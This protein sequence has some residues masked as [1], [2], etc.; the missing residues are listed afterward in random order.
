[1]SD[2]KKIKVLKVISGTYIDKT[3]GE[4]KKR[5]LEIGNIFQDSRKGDLKIKIDSLPVMKGGWDGWA[6][7]Y[8]L[9]EYAPN[10]PFNQG[11]EDMDQSIPF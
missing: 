4:E 7:A 5:Y 10:K 3:T 2:L 9:K 1:M 8:E 11:N 6:N